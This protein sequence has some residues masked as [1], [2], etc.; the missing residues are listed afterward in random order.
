VVEATFPEVV[1]I[2]LQFQFMGDQGEGTGVC[3]RD[4]NFSFCLGARMLTTGE[5]GAGTPVVGG[6][7]TI[8]GG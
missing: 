1:S 7:M 4:V 2:F 6:L 5:V 8:S 3:T